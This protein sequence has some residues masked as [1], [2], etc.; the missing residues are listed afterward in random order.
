[1]T[2]TDL[3]RAYLG[4]GSYEKAVE[5]GDMALGLSSDDGDSELS[6]E[7]R[8]KARL[9]AHMTVGLAHYY[10][11]RF[12]DALKY[13]ESALEES[14]GNP[15]AVCLLTQVLWAQG[16]EEARERAREA[17]FEVIGE[18]PDHVQSVLLL[19][20]IA[21]LD[22]DPDSLEAVTEALESLRTNDKVTPTQ[23]SHIGE[24]LRAIATLAEDKS[25]QD[26]TTQAQT[27]IMLFPNLPH[28]WSAL[29]E[30]TGDEYTAQMA[31]K[32][33][34]KGIPPRGT[35]ECHDLTK[36][37]AGTGL[38]S[39]AQK[40]A[41]LAPWESEGWASLAIATQGI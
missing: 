31:L 34:Q 8:K 29:T 12:D 1:M 32:V 39:D 13:F 41:F 9:S 38:A 35:L 5:C 11:N 2:R 37:Y 17:L 25:E 30:A 28:G 23:Q 6:G 40:A 7:Q 18:R 15:D 16:S 21:L 27:D 24:V 4:A 36:A 3:A 33:A 26:T 19:G 14:D 20:V 22:N 10:A